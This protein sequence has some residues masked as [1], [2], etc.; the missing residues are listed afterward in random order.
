[1]IRNNPDKEGRKSRFFGSHTG[2]TWVVLGMIFLVVATLLIYRGAQINTGVFPYPHGAFAS[3]IV[4]HWLAPLGYGVN[5]VLE[6]TFILAQIAVIMAFAVIV[7]NPKAHYW[8]GSTPGAD[9]GQWLAGADR[10][11]GSWWEA[12]ANWVTARAGERQ[13]PPES[14]GSERHPVLCP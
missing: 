11:Q 6:V 9:P 7:G 10:Q 2:A 4:A 3:E 8:T 14:L 1:R 13:P 12:W 5:G